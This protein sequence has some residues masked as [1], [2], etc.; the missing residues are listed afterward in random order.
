MSRTL[1]LLALLL[2]ACASSQVILYKP[3]ESEAAWRITVTKKPL[4]T[5]FECVINDSSVVSEPFALFSNN[6]EK[7]GI[8]GGKKIKMLGFRETHV[9]VGA[10]AQV[11]SSSTYQIR[12]FIDEKEVGKFDFHD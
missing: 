10:S 7:D 4:S 9:S 11:S 12:I 1:V 3:S 6:L 8:Y 5:I 2:A